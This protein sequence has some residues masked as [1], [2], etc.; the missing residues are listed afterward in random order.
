MDRRDLLRSVWG[1]FMAQKARTAL[2]LSG[3][4]IGVGTIVAL[5]SLVGGGLAAIQGSVQDAAGDDLITA[6]MRYRDERGRRA[7]PL[8]IHD[9]AAVA[10]APR[11]EQGMVVPQLEFRSVAKAKGKEERAWIV[12]T[13]AEAPR[14]YRFELG[15]GRFILPVDQAGAARVAVLGA[16]MAQNLGIGG[17]GGAR[18]SGGRPGG[19]RANRIARRNLGEAGSLANGTAFG[20]NGEGRRPG[21]RQRDLGFINLGGDRF[22]VVGVLADKPYLNVGNRSWNQAVI[23]PDSTFVAWRGPQQVSEILAYTRAPSERL[24]VE[25]PLART[26][27]TAILALRQHPANM[28]QTEDKTTKS[29]SER[30]F[31]LALQVLVVAVSL[32]CMLTGGINIMNIMLVTVSERTREIG[33]RLAVGATPGV[34]QAQFLAEATALATLGGLL[35]AGGGVLLAWV[36]SLILKATL[37]N[38][39]FMIA[40][41]ALGGALVA[42]LATGI[43]F[44]WYPARVAAQLDPVTALRYE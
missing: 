15:Q 1:T 33:L 19:G 31:L 28:I 8:T 24:T 17:R 25:L 37:G 43:G 40:W 5:S 34:I 29:Q 18:A 6:R 39:P 20:A 7:R 41:G 26:A 30:G 32:V 42:A 14:I 3:L 35:G 2:T 38:W 10:T 44:G 9:V 12:G 21:G 4:I 22:R 16:T 27:M 23:I 11:F 36:G 13:N